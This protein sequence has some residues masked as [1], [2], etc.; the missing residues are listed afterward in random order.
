MKKAL[1]MQVVLQ[2]A[3]SQEWFACIMSDLRQSGKGVKCWSGYGALFRSYV[4]RGS[5]YMSSCRDHSL[6][7]A[8]L[9]G[10]W[11]TPGH[12][13]TGQAPLLVR[14]GMPEDRKVQQDVNT[15]LVKQGTELG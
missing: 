10:W 9:Q 12:T 6:G 2:N 15:C 5:P 1:I 14:L 7:S 4:I 8:P 13:C 11:M 3:F